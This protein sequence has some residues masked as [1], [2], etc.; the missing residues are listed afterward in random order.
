MNIFANHKPIEVLNTTGDLHSYRY[1]GE[2]ME[3]LGARLDAARSALTQ[4][5]SAWAQWYWQETVNRLLTQWRMLPILQ[6]GQARHTLIPRW[7]VDYE[8]WEDREEV[9]YTGIESVADKMFD[10]IFRSSDLD[11]SWRRVRDERIMKCNCQ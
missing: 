11:D 3:S 8:F 6:D 1:I 9:G 2:E 10:N 4:A 5:K 7:S